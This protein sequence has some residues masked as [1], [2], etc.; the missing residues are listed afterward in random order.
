MAS[1]RIMI[2]ELKPELKQIIFFHHP[3]PDGVT[4]AVVLAKKFGTSDNVSYVGLNHMNVAEMRKII[5]SHVN[6]KV[7]I[8]FVDIT[9]PYSILISML[10]DKNITHITLL[11][12]HLTAINEINSHQD[13][14]DLYK[15]S[16]LLKTQFEL[17]KSGAGIAHDFVEK[18]KEMPSYVRLAQ[19]VDLLTATG[20]TK[21][22]NEFK[23]CEESPV[24]SALAEMV[25]DKEIKENI[26]FFGLAA[27]YDKKMDEFFV[28]NNNTPFKEL[29]AA[30]SEFYGTLEEKGMSYLLGSSVQTL[31][32]KQVNDQRAAISK[33]VVITSPHDSAMDVLLIEANIRSGRTFDVLI[34]SKLR[35]LH[36]KNSR[37]IFAMVAQFDESANCYRVALRGADDSIDLSKIA[38][39]FKKQNLAMNAGGHARASALQ[40]SR[41]QMGEIVDQAAAVR[42]HLLL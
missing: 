31:F 33:A 8:Y 1:T 41:E 30:V 38:A 27:V 11:D 42:E 17:S 4:G 19:T 10:Q 40:L 12:H 20:D 16:G 36:A 26:K 39:E 18:E 23:I 13:I 9:P 21:V 28:K 6:Q 22:I 35:E 3:C 7:Q 37:P 2:N 34:S 29:M 5:F 14:L 32:Q 25:D 15:F 24:F